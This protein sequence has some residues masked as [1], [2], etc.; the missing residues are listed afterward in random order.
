M[1]FNSETSK[2]LTTNRK[3]LNQY[4]VVKQKLERRNKTCNKYSPILQKCFYIIEKKLNLNAFKWILKVKLYKYQQVAVV[5]E[6]VVNQ[7]WLQ[8]R[9]LKRT[10]LAQNNHQ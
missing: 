6:K 7:I 9:N 1:K 4:L 3:V 5:Q 10:K 2:K 8:N